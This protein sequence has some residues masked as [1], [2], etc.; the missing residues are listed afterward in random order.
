MEELK[1][2]E[3][4]TNAIISYL[5]IQ[6]GDFIIELLTRRELFI[7]KNINM[8]DQEWHDW[9]SFCDNLKNEFK[10]IELFIRKWEEHKENN[11]K[12]FNYKY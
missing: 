8:G 7:E 9:T 12:H 10:I 4:T 2:S 3:M 11:P 5:R 1:I 6:R